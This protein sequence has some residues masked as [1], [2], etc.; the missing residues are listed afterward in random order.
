[1]TNPFKG[2]FE[3]MITDTERDEFYQVARRG[4]LNDDPNFNVYG[5][6]LYQGLREYDKLKM[7]HAK[8]KREKEIRHNAQQ[9]ERN[10]T[11]FR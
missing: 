8:A 5:R 10:R 11:S 6:L 1:M 9:I 3:V 2:V 4:V 7:P